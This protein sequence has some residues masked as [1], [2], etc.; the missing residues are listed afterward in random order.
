M[1]HINETAYFIKKSKVNLQKIEKIEMFLKVF[2]KEQ[3]L[4]KTVALH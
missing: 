2:L 4:R 3:V 1:S